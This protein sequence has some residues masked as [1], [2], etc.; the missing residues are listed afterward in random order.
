[1]NVFET[2]LDGQLAVFWELLVFGAD[3]QVG[4]VLLEG[5]E[6][7]ALAVSELKLTISGNLDIADFLELKVQLVGSGNFHFLAHRYKF[8]FP[9]RFDNFKFNLRRN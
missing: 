9:E 2:L 5:F 4:G 3:Q 6:D 8:P 7:Q 1:M